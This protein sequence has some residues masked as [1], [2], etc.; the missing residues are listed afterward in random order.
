MPEALQRLNLGCGQIMPAGWLNCDSSWHAQLSNQPLLARLARWVRLVGASDWPKGVRYLNLNKK[1]RFPE[2]CAGVVYA[3]HVLE[4]L[5]PAATNLF[6]KE[7][8]RVLVPGGVL[9]V[10]V[11]DLE[12]HAREYLTA[13]RRGPDAARQFLWA[14]NLGL[15]QHRNWIH[16]LY[17]VWMGHPSMHKTMYDEQVLSE[18]LVGAGFVD[19]RRCE[20]GQ[21]ERIGDLELLESAEGYAHS[22]YVEAVRA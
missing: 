16:A 18:M 22:L 12:G 20:R 9:R 19:I 15:P 5:S 11:P 1:W 10:V 14:M 13:A 7:S 17:D 3:S 2:S 21:S 6:L 8:S 4:H